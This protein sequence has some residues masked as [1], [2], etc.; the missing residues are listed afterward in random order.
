M[1]VHTNKNTHLTFFLPKFKWWH[2]SIIPNCCYSFS[3][4]NLPYMC[5]FTKNDAIS[6]KINWE[7]LH[8]K[9]IQLNLK[10][11]ENAYVFFLCSSLCHLCKINGS[12]PTFYNFLHCSNWLKNFFQKSSNNSKVGAVI[13]LLA[14]KKFY[15]LD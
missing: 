1:S 7:S 9:Q 3:F 4:F 11:R 10:S 8:H 12:N 15:L 6:H 14:V 5:C 2:L 13:S